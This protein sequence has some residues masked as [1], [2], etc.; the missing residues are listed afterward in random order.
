MLNT[1]LKMKLKLIKTYTNFTLKFKNLSQK[2]L[3]VS[4]VLVLIIISPTLILRINYLYLLFPHIGKEV[5]ITY[6]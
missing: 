5:N 1:L 2:L 3:S 6:S 4:L